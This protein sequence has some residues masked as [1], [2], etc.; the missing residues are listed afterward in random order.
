MAA[1]ATT[2]LANAPQLTSR[3]QR[4][5]HVDA[6]RGILLVFM[7]VNHIPSDL[8][9]AT[10]HIFGFVSGAEGFV[11]LSG[12]M[13]GLVYAR[14]YYKSGAAALKAA[15]ASRAREVYRFHA[16]TFL[17]VLLGVQLCSVW[18][19]APP[20][21]TPPIMLDHPIRALLGGL[22]LV[23][24]PSLF[25]I[26]PMYCV[27]LLTVPAIIVACS[28][29]HHS[30]VLVTSFLLWLM[31]NLFSPQTP[32]INGVVNTGSFNL[33]S[34]Q[35]L[36][37]V[38]TVFGH[39]WATGQRLWPKPHAGLIAVALAVA[40]VLYATR[41]ALIVAPLSGSALDWLTNKN[42]VAPLRL[43]NTALLFYLVYV[44]VARFP[45]LVS[46][47]PLAFL[48]QH[49]MFAF[50]AHILV[51]YG[52]QSFP[53]KLAATASGRAVATA[54]MIGSLFAAAAIHTALQT[55]AKRRAEELRSG[56]GW[57]PVAKMGNE[58]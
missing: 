12:L 56:Q 5:I 1:T 15:A 58:S 3:S 44:V 9:I 35:L 24:Q 57:L 31:A 14:R 4:F 36:F 50:A 55:R 51:A 25:D 26:L 32:H 13:S 2:R 42:N 20:V 27:L 8:Q 54:I 22:T 28:R 53:E 17:V 18:L 34:W 16:F 6:L 38:G 19:G 47:R 37:V 7:V 49:S 33:L 48:G 45:N 43:L 40:A 39:A 23:Q 10:N 29:R 52:I 21:I 11:F 46:W 30:A 41:H